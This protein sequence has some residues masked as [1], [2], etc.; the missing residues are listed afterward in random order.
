MVAANPKSRNMHLY[1]V[2]QQPASQPRMPMNT[3][4]NEIP[5]VHEI[6]VAQSLNWDGLFID[7]N[8]DNLETFKRQENSNPAKKRIRRYLQ[9][10]H[11]L[12]F[13]NPLHQTKARHHKPSKKDLS[14]Q[15]KEEDHGE[16]ELGLGS[17]F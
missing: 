12:L 14:L 9:W 17:S 16:F 2:R 6:H 8:D 11:S 4:D 5:L 15:Q 10:V 1:V 7:C 13:H 3:V